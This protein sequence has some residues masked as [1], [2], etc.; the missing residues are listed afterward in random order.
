MCDDWEDWEL[1]A[2]PILNLQNNE[3]MN[4]LLE[5]RRLV[6][7]SDAALSKELFEEEEEDEEDSLLYKEMKQ[8]FQQ[9]KTRMKKEISPE[10][11]KRNLQ[12]CIE[13][14]AKQKEFSIKNKE[15]K[16]AKIREIELFGESSEECNE[17]DSYE[18]KYCN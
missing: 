16:A 15:Q 8:K 10:I 13:N 6:E 12:K 17:Y 9:L 11:K 3:R 2:I 14:E 1:D 7:E 5:E 4:K 18:D